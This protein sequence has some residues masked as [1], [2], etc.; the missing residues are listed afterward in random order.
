M[1]D[2]GEITPRK[3]SVAEPNWDEF[4]ENESELNWFGRRLHSAQKRSMGRVFN[5]IGLP[6][7]SKIL[8]VGCG[9]GRS[10]H[11]LRSLGYTNSIGI[12][13]SIKSI[14]L[15]EKSGFMIDKDVFLMDATNTTFDDSEFE[16]VLSQG[17]LE[18]FADFSPLVREMSR[19]SGRYVL[20]SQPNHFSLYR[21]MVDYLRGT[22]ADEYTDYEVS[23]YEQA[24]E[25]AG[26]N[27]AQSFSINMHEQFVLLF[28]KVDQ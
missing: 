3:I 16:L 10:L 25:R 7:N 6:R 8:D 23:D 21:K 13:S 4:W 1:I 15:C 18:H 19:I 24:F 26:F 5:D 17:L 2:I 27:L 14:E 12:D 28:K 22:P 9:S 20:L 11:D